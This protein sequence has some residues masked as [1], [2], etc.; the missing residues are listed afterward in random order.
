MGQDFVLVLAPEAG[1]AALGGWENFPG[2]LPAWPTARVVKALAGVP[3]LEHDG[4]TFWS[5]DLEEFEVDPEQVQAIFFTTH[6]DSD[7]EAVRISRHLANL[8]GPVT[9]VQAGTDDRVEIAPG[10]SEGIGDA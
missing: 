10:S 3:G 9:L 7:Q 5:E 6:G 2:D 1:F 4:L 8:V